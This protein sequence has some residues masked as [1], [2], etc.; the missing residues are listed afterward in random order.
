MSLF[1][2]R[3]NCA[4]GFFDTTPGFLD[5]YTDPSYCHLPENIHYLCYNEDLSSSNWNNWSS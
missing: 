2:F 4:C 1:H 3:E 5:I